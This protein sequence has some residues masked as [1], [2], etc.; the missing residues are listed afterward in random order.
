MV[1][2]VVLRSEALLRRVAKGD[3]VPTEH[4]GRGVPGAFHFD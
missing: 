3:H 1:I 4:V 2:P